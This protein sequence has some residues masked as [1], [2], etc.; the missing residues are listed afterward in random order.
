MT[1]S[2]LCPKIFDNHCTVARI[3][4]E[5]EVETGAE[6]REGRDDR[7][8]MSSKVACLFAEPRPISCWRFLSALLRI[9]A[10]E[11]GSPRCPLARVA[12]INTQCDSLP[13]KKRVDRACVTDS[14]CKHPRRHLH[15]YVPRHRR[16]L[17]W[18]TI[19]ATLIRR[20]LLAS[21]IL[22]QNAG[23]NE[24]GFSSRP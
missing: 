14:L 6:N 22:E 18:S 23:N 21:I 3:D 24:A 9:V 2:T 8:K 15:L 16:R 5:D 7:A 13:G 17:L 10:S 20:S 12:L 11:K 4:G 19:H 1:E